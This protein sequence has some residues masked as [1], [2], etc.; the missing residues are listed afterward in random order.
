ML[1]TFLNLDNANKEKDI[2]E[3]II[4]L[5][6]NENFN[7]KISKTSNFNESIDYVFWGYGRV[8]SVNLKNTSIQI[9]TNV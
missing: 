9:F 3:F 6:D 2:N 4:I 1:I 5:K 7:S 8:F